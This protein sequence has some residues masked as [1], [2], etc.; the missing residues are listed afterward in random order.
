MS[1][2]RIHTTPK[3]LHYLKYIINQITN[4]NKKKEKS[5]KT[6]K[7]TITSRNKIAKQADLT[8]FYNLRRKKRFS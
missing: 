8:T 5:S 7:K 4:N 6:Q 1:L 2:P 3:A